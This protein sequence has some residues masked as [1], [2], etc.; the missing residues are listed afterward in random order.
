MRKV[1]SEA[2]P[3]PG[4]LRPGTRIGEYRLREV[5]GRGG[6]GTVYR[7]THAEIGSEV[8]IKVLAGNWAGSGA[9]SAERFL[10]EARAASRVR[11]INI[12]QVFSLGRLDDGGLYYV[13]E[14]LGG[15]PLR[16]YLA[17]LGPLE[18]RPTLSI[19]RALASALDALHASSVVHRDIK[20]SNVFIVRP[21]LGIAEAQVKLLDFG[22]ARLLDPRPGAE[23]LTATGAVVGTPAY[24]SPEQ[25]RGRP[26]SPRSDIYALGV[27]TFELLSGQRPYAAQ[28]LGDLALQQQA[29][30]SLTLQEVAPD[31]P[32]GVGPVIARAMH[33]KP[34]SRFCRAGDFAQAL[35]EACGVESAPVEP[36]T[37]W[38]EATLPPGKLGPPSGGTVSMASAPHSARR[39]RGKL[40]LAAVGLLVAIASLIA[41]GVSSRTAPASDQ[42]VS[43]PAADAGVVGETGPEARSLL[44]TP[45]PPQD[46]QVIGVT[47]KLRTTPRT[48]KRRRRRAAAR[49]RRAT[50]RKKDRVVRDMP[51]R[52]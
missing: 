30:E 31:L 9:P 34:A 52:F 35:A 39:L 41:W 44:T 2:S 17:E 46:A 11:H 28:S 40:A 25:C 49:K 42:V 22:V 24:M 26:A 6:M 8:A 18:P 7:A 5:I 47:V 15:L 12:V 10:Q 20:P 21:D 13:M 50:K 33:T 1:Q 23:L 29:G 36:A 32:D 37:P 4:D 27:L 43:K 16:S 19:V 3:A 38:A 51:V 14:L 48:N 45:V